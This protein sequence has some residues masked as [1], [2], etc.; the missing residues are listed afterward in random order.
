MSSAP[1]RKSG[2][3][4]DQ[5]VIILPS[6]TIFDH[7]VLTHDLCPAASVLHHQTVKPPSSERQ[8]RDATPRI[9]QVT[10]KLTRFCGPVRLE[11]WIR[12]TGMKY[13]W[14]LRHVGGRKWRKKKK[15][16]K[17]WSWSQPAGLTLSPTFGLRLSAGTNALPGLERFVFVICRVKMSFSF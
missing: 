11:V 10:W 17:S 7:L 14:K 15:G 3:C 4:S 12:T 5:R 16:K 6:H 13:R 8:R 2:L 1:G 9:L